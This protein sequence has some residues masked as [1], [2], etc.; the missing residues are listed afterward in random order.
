MRKRYGSL[1]RALARHGVGSA[2]ARNI[3]HKLTT[4][5]LEF[6]FAPKRLDQLAEQVRALARQARPLERDI[7]D[8]CTSKARMSWKVFL[9]SFT[10]NETNPDWVAGLIESGA[11]DTDRLMAHIVLRGTNQRMSAYWAGETHN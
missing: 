8:I 1:T 4:K 10:G 3:Q 6:E 7:R 5:F 2:Q 9:K 11:G